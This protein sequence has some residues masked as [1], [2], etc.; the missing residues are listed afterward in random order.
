MEV[1]VMD[2]EM[3]FL[4]VLACIALIICGACLYIIFKIAPWALK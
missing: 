3:K 2:K 1:L 4:L